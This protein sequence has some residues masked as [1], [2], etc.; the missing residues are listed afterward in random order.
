MTL[1]F[2]HEGT[3]A[4]PVG[5]GQVL[6]FEKVRFKLSLGAHGDTMTGTLVDEIDDTDG[7]AVFVG[8]GTFEASRI[9]VEP[10]P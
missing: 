5:S 6:A 8:P 1:R 4:N 9:A 2:I 10:L 3:D 7:N